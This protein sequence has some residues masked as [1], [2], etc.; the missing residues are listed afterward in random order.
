LDTVSPG[1]HTYSVTATSLDGQT[2]TSSISYLVAS[3]PTIT[4]NAPAG[5]TSYNPNDRTV[6]S[7]S[8]QDGAGGPGIQS[9][10]GTLRN[11]AALPTKP[12]SYGFTVTATSR[13]G[14]SQAVTVQYT[15]GEPFALSTAI[16]PTTAGTSAA[17][18]PEAVE[19]TFLL[20]SLVKNGGF[21]GDVRLDDPYTLTLPQGFT[22]RTAGYGACDSLRAERKRL[23]ASCSDAVLGSGTLS[24]ELPP[25]SAS[26]GAPVGCAYNVAVL[27]LAHPKHEVLRLDAERAGSSADCPSRPVL[28]DIRIGASPATLTFQLPESVVGNS[29][30]SPV[31]TSATQVNGSLFFPIARSGRST[32][33][34][35]ASTGCDRRRSGPGFA[36]IFGLSVG[37]SLSTSATT[38]CAPAG[39]DAVTTARGRSQSVT[40][41]VVHLI[42]KSSAFVVARA[43][44]KL[45]K[46]ATP[47]PLPA[48]GTQVTVGIRPLIGGQWAQTCL[49]TQGGSAVAA[50]MRGT[51]TFRL[52]ARREFVL[53][54]GG[55]SILLKDSGRLPPLLHNV[56][57][58]VSINGSA[59]T[60]EMVTVGGLHKGKLVIS[61]ILEKLVK[62]K[63]DGG[64]IATTYSFSPDD[65]GGA[66]AQGYTL[67]GQAPDGLSAG[68]PQ[69]DPFELIFDNPTGKGSGIKSKPSKIVLDMFKG[70]GATAEQ[71]CTTA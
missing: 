3:A 46:I 29:S 11:G 27:L 41:T 57:V 66:P 30:A 35:F 8:C 55:S 56:T 69:R 49:T 40:G 12:G 43:D 13:D 42:K 47:S 48:I 1:R 65:G 51:V 61:G 20:P 16:S 25:S 39:A 54:A 45:Y 63:L 62:H 18:A 31:S 71:L 37:T 59:L 24:V 9:C 15:V 14:L 68:R 44:G 28:V 5:H 19:L 17:P 22:A 2:S 58:H 70:F 33:S 10:V 7:Y 4:L 64:S 26:G 34:Y 23:P 67:N 6:V 50:T 38:T 52:R 21:I 32:R 36:W 60:V 53:T